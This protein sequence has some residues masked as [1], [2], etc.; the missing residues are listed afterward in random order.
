[1]MSHLNID[2]LY[3]TFKIFQNNLKFLFSCLLVNRT[4]CKLAVP[5]LWKDPW[6]ILSDTQ[7]KTLLNVITSHFT[8]DEL[9]KKLTF[10]YISF[11]KHLNFCEIKR[12]I[13]KYK[14]E[15]SVSD[16]IIKL[17][18]SEHAKYTHI[19]LPCEFN[20]QIHL[21]PGAKHCFSDLTYVKCNTSIKDTVLI[22]LVEMCKSIKELKLEFII[23][24]S[25]NNYRVYKLI[26]V[27]KKISHVSFLSYNYYNDESLCKILEK[28][29]IKHA[30]T[31][32]SIEIVKQPVT[33]FLS[34]LVNLKKLEL[35]D[36]YNRSSWKILE[37]L[38]LPSL[39]I[40]KAAQ[41]PITALIPLIERTRGSLIEINIDDSRHN[42][43]NNKRV[44]QAIY[45]NCPNLKYLKILLKNSNFVEL[46]KLLINCKRLEGLYILENSQGDNEFFDWEI[47]F[48]TLTKSSPSNLFKFKFQFIRAPS[49]K[50]LRYFFKGWYNRLPMLLQTNQV[51][52]DWGYIDMAP[53]WS[54]YY[55][56][57]NRYGDKIVKK[58]D[59]SWDI[60]NFEDFEWIEKK[61]SKI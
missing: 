56:L 51:P 29:L 48:E 25:N 28:S 60:V 18:I 15:K 3:L 39:Q 42:K 33:E 17:F 10:N 1:M 36:F 30:I 20:L 23:N 37:N 44:L 55:N 7:E 19:Y 8:E 31:M 41:L 38:T 47:L 46:N 12:M 14:I 21:I 57:V 9:N 43:V 59:Y 52:P 35:I 49:L 4:W 45:K 32:E 54:K 6:K 50:S 27:A 24:P 53:D 40:L 58:Y 26:E 61:K 2:T 11:C 34:S 13:V 5:L 22:G 16:K